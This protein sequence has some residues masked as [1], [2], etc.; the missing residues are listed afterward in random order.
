MIHQKYPVEGMSC[1][2]CSAHVTKAL[3]GVEGVTEV[4]VNLPM[5]TAEVTYDPAR[6]TPDDLRQAVERMG[7][8]LLTDRPLLATSAD[9]APA[10]ADVE[11]RTDAGRA[12][13]EAEARF[14]LRYT[15]L[16][17]S[18]WGA[19]AV[20]VPLLVLSLVPH[21]FSGQEFLLFLLASFSLWRYGREFYR[22]AWRLLRHGTSNMD[23]LV[24]MS[25]SVAY[26]FSCFN[27]FFPQFFTARGMQPQLYFD[28]SGVITAFILLGRLMEARAKRQT[29]R[30]IRQLMGLQ[31]KEVTRLGADGGAERV[32]VTAVRVG[33]CLL[34]R[35]GERVAA[36]GVVTDGCS[37]VDESMLSGEPVPVSKQP[38]DAVKAGTGN[39]RGTLTFRA[40]QVGA[41]T[42]LARIVQLV[43][44]AQGSKA[45]VQQ[46]VDRIA[47][48]F[49]PVIIGISVIALV[50]WLCFDPAEG[51]VRGLLSM[52]SVLVVACPCSLGLATPTALIVGIGRGARE[53][54]LVKDAASLQVACRIDTVVLDKTGTV[55]EGHPRLVRTAFAPGVDVD[56]CRQMC[57]SLE[58]LGTH[59]LAEA[60]CEGL[61][62]ANLLPVEDFENLPGE[63]ACGMVGGHR[64]HVGSWALMQRLHRTVP[65]PLKQVAEEW[66]CEAFSLVALADEE[67]VVALFAVADEVKPTSVQALAQLRA[68]GIRTHLLTGD[69]EAPARAVA[70]RVGADEVKARVMPAD[71]AA[72]V[73]RLQRE[74]HCV[75][76]VGDGIN[77]SAALAKADLS[78]AMGQ[79]SDVAIEAAMLTLLSS[80]LQKLPSAIRLSKLTTRTIRQNLFWAFIYNAV[81]VPIAAGLLYPVCG[82]M[83]S[84]M[85]A[86]AAM[87]LSSVS[88]VSNSL[89]SRRESISQ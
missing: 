27:L 19:L 74:G 57:L 36:D 17:R 77:D 80:D 33:D 49:V 89:R 9:E 21:L 44:E 85:V 88:V 64:W 23:T 84:P 3:Q 50:L 12:E 39:G 6:C 65:E 41:D 25:I 67:T 60:L 81:S 1:A 20:A 51:W 5:N 61:K 30:S 29:G 28:S 69:A 55:T 70:E 86:G 52:V 42:L 38:G 83:L 10:G 14:Q 47:A 11:Q 7:F 58:R 18:A 4:N 68:M 16:R 79:G 48:V 35:P 43:Q 32:A 13:A 22:G 56:R 62:E 53:G 2:S 73:Q 46:L 31:P 71:K 54:I 59:P 76:M 66:Q 63:G 87:A 82:F 26:L 78:V 45:P 37:N 24:A 15:Q 72:Y 34:V 75:A 8:G 40:T